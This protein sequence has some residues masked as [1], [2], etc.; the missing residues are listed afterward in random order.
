M[1][2]TFIHLFLMWSIW[3]PFICSFQ[4]KFPQFLFSWTAKR[5]LNL[6]L[7]FFC[8]IYSYLMF[9]HVHKDTKAHI[10]IRIHTHIDMTKGFLLL[11]ESNF[12]FLRT[13]LLIIYNPP[14][15]VDMKAF[16]AVSL[17]RSNTVFHHFLAITVRWKCLQE[18]IEEWESVCRWCVCVCVKALLKKTDPISEYDKRLIPN[19][20]KVTKK[21]DKKW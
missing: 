14:N 6:K 2:D 13:A 3:S 20:G 10:H 16:I 8:I 1:G 7:Q 4:S 19:T 17:L 21:K 18:M 5:A 12:N 11:W 9:K 15:L